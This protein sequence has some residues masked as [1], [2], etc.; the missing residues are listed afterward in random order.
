[1]SSLLP[2]PQA[3][4]GKGVP[5]DGYNLASLPREVALLPTLTTFGK[6]VPIIR[7]WEQILG[8]P[9]PL[10]TTHNRLGNPT[11]SPTFVE[12][13][14]GLPQGWVTGIPGLTRIKQL[15]ALGNGVV[16]QQATKAIRRL[17]NE[18]NNAASRPDDRFT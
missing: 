1:M 8:R 11:L 13:M 6:Y 4:D 17:L 2:T 15:R 10:P 5:G 14:M 18:T 12:W 16:P 3:R 7:R 9:A